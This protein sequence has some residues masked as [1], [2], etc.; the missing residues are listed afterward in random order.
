MV[1]APWAVSLGPA[2][3]HNCGL[4]VAADQFWTPG[5]VFFF[6]IGTRLCAEK[7]QDFILTAGHGQQVHS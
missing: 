6:L 5:A 1:L 2:C 3:K 7:D 4:V